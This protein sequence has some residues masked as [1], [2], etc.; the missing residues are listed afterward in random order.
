MISHTLWKD[1]IESLGGNKE[2]QDVIMISCGGERVGVYILFF[3]FWCL[4][5]FMYTCQFSKFSVMS[6]YNFI[7]KKMLPL[8]GSVG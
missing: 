3:F 6:V 7:T 5:S 1:I 4:Y 2:Y 8:G